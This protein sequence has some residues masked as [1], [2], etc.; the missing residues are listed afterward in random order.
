MYWVSCTVKDNNKKSTTIVYDGRECK[1]KFIECPMVLISLDFLPLR[2]YFYLSRYFSLSLFLFFSRC[3][4]AFP[5]LSG[6][7]IL[8][9]AERMK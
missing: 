1:I 7:L 8:L 9:H 3:H 5:A 4:F 2:H 6:L